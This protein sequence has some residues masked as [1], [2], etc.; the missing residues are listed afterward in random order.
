LDPQR[1]TLNIN[2]AIMVEAGHSPSVRL[3]EAAACGTPIISDYWEGLDS[4]FRPGREILIARSS[5]ECLRYLLEIT[6]PERHAIGARARALVLA[7][8]TAKHRALEL[9]TC[10]RGVLTTGMVGSSE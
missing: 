5:E 3:F 1:F 2:R 9:E 6:E 8:H 4:F 7:Q 10:V